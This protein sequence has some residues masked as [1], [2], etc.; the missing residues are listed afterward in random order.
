MLRDDRGLAVYSASG[1]AINAIAAK[2][3][4]ELTREDALTAACDAVP[5]ATIFARGPLCPFVL[6]RFSAFELRD[7]RATWL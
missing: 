6:D 5:M 1:N 3:P 4:E 2:K 7:S